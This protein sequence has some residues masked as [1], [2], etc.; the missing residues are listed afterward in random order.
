MSLICENYLNY[1]FKYSEQFLNISEMWKNP[2][3]MI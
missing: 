2:Y 1:N 3:L